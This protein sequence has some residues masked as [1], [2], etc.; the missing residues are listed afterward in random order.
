MESL[1]KTKLPRH[2]AIIMDGNGRWAKNKSLPRIEGHTRGADVVEDITEAAR[3]T[4]IKYITLYAFSKENWNRPGDETAALMALLDHFLTTKREKMIKNGIRLNAIGEVSQ[5]PAHV[6]EKLNFTIKET[7][8]G[9]EMV[10]TLALS[11]GSRD[12]ITR[13]VKSISKDILN[14][15]ITPDHID[16]SLI[17]GYLDTSDMPDPDFIIR[18]SGESRISNFLLWQAAYAE[19]MFVETCWPDFNKELFLKCLSD[20]QERERRFGR[21]SEQLD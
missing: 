3:E 8:V 10:L 19:L 9:K 20:Y 5:L 18:T 17:S 21:T 14:K 1:D 13:A 15:K 2:V 12:E 4:G 7:S 11:Y 6:L 16:D